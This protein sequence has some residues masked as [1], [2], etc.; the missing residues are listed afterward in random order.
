MGGGLLFKKKKKEKISPHYKSLAK[1]I[2]EITL[3][4][5]VGM[6]GTVCALL[7][8]LEKYIST[9]VVIFFFIHV[10]YFVCEE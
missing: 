4:G 1:E 5:V 7:V 3:F 9:H 2:L 6:V 8:F 10:L